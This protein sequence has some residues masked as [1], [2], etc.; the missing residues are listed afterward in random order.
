[1]EGTGKAEPRSSRRAQA[2]HRAGGREIVGKNWRSGSTENLLREMD[3]REDAFRKQRY[4][5]RRLIAPSSNRTFDDT[6]QLGH[7]IASAVYLTSDQKR[8][9]C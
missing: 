4:R 2:K 1:V 3:G 6:Y 5:E 9:D 7:R 8:N